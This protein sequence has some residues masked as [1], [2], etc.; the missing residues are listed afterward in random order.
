ML[1]EWPLAP[2]RR[3]RTCPIL[4][5][6]AH[7]ALPDR[8]S[9]LGPARR[10]SS[11]RTRSFYAGAASPASAGGNDKPRDHHQDY[12]GNHQKHGDQIERTLQGRQRRALLH[13]Q[14]RGQRNWSRSF[15]RSDAHSR[16]ARRWL[17][18]LRPDGQRQRS[19]A[20]RGAETPANT[21]ATTPTTTPATTPAT[22]FRILETPHKTMSGVWVFVIFLKK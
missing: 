19:F 3:P 15:G 20:A 9:S 13:P 2:G 5:T 11:T 21:P 8:L 10:R 22:T 14:L 12:A 17:P 16:R 6:R 18:E 7:D 4:G 1:D